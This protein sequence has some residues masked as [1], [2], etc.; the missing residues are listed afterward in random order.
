MNEFRFGERLFIIVAPVLLSACSTIDQLELGDLIPERKVDYKSSKS[1]PPLEVP[2]DLT[3]SSVDDAMVVPDVRTGGT[4]TY[5]DYSRERSGPGAVRRDVVMPEVS[6]QPAHRSPTQLASANPQPV[7]AGGIELRVERDGNKQWIVVGD[8]PARVW[9]RV[10]DFWLENGFLIKIEDPRIG[11]METDWAENR[12]DIPDD[13]IRNVLKKFMDFAYSAATR[14]KFRIRL[15]HGKKENTTEIYISHR[16]VEE[17]AQGETFVWQPRQSDPELEAEMLKR[18]AVFFGAEDRKVRRMLAARNNQATRAQLTRDRQGRVSLMVLEDFSRTWRRT[19]L[20]LDRVGFTVADRDRSRGLYY[21]QYVDPLDDAD[22][23]KGWVSK[24]AFWRG[25][26]KNNEDYLIS[27]IGEGS[28]TRVVVL[29]T[30]GKLD[31][32]KTA[33]RILALLHEQ[34]R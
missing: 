2:P 6:Q 21:V 1:L 19:G 25:K 28:K 24:L 14:D 32:G 33:G 30:K 18:L 10:R 13:P 4:A 34:L 23:P 3:R 5:S 29:N 7:L 9:P 27:L 26:K 12:A 11:I 15:E 31:Q 20:A 8:A 17:V 22:Q 16:G